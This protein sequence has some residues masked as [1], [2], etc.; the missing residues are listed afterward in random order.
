MYIYIYLNR[1]TYTYIF[2]YIFIYLFICMYS[3]AR[4]LAYLAHVLFILRGWEFIS[5]K[6]KAFVPSFSMNSVWKTY[7]G[8]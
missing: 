6:H 1:F 5:P 4:T 2:I 7:T 8:T 3:I